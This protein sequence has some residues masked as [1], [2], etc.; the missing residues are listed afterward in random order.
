[1]NEVARTNDVPQTAGQGRR[2][3]AL[4]L[5]TALVL[6]LALAGVVG[7]AL[8]RRGAEA[9]ERNARAAIPI[10]AHRPSGSS[11]RPQSMGRSCH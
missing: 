4:T 5:G 7:L 9:R 3:R 8:S 1:M 6:M 11:G 10:L 2:P